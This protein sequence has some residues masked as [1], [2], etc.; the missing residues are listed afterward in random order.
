VS[1]QE[2]LLS[3]TAGTILAPTNKVGCVATR[4]RGR[5]LV[6]SFLE[7]F[8]RNCREEP[9]ERP[10]LTTLKEL[11]KVLLYQSEMQRRIEVL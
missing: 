2:F 6:Q 4:T 7:G 3:A 10:V 9:G 11:S 1:Q 8:L 5:I